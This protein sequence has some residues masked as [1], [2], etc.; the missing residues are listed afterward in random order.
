VGENTIPLDTVGDN[1]IYKLM[2]GENTN[3]LEHLLPQRH[4]QNDIFI[5]DVADAVL[6]DVMQHMEHPFYSLSK[7]PETAIRRY[8]H[9]GNVLEITPS[10]KGLATIYDKDILIYC[11]SQIMAKLN[12]GEKVSQ[13]VRINSRELLIFTNRGTSGREYLS[14]Q[15]G[16]DRLAGTRIRTDIRT[17][18]EVQYENFGLIE[19]AGMRRKEGVDGRLIYCDIKLSD[20]VFN[21]IR[22]NEVLTL[23]RDYFRLRKPIER[24]IYELARKHC[25]SQ[26]ELEIRVDTLHHKSGSKSDL[27]EFRRAVREL[28]QGN[29]LPDYEVHFDDVTDRVRFVNRRTMSGALSSSEPWQGRLDPDVM[30]D[31]RGH[32]PG[33]DIHHLEREWRNW[34]GEKKITPRH[35]ARNFIK[36]CDSWFAK[37]GRP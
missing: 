24:R 7:K 31:A 5:C 27:K 36:F 32:A 35:P 16:L 13:T 29:H 8:E 30:H 21:A 20:W 14:L 25:G 2:V 11:I 17:G 9:N 22:H 15:E 34:L 37:R 1:T 26:A 4:P 18:D 3:P 10:V 19:N 12:R 23:S 28:A 6:K 33:W